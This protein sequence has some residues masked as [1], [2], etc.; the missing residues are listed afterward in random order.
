MTGGTIPELFSQ[1][2]PN[3]LPLSSDCE[4]FYPQLNQTSIRL[5]HTNARSPSDTLGVTLVH[6]MP[7]FTKFLVRINGGEW[8]VSDDQFPWVLAKG[9]NSIEAK[10]VN[11][12]GIEG[13]ISKI[14]L[15][16]NI[17]S[18]W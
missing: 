13:G 9:E 2:M 14:R 8:K 11:A 17:H 15:K 3:R 16:N 5:R 6:T 1:G 7:W 4:Y 12:A 18:S 10:A